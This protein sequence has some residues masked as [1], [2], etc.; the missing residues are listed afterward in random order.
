MTPNP[1][2][3]GTT[4]DSAFTSLQ[5]SILGYVGDGIALVVAV[6]AIAIGVRLL[7]KYVKMAAGKGA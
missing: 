3:D 2:A 4:I 5:G 7:V 6:V 1:P